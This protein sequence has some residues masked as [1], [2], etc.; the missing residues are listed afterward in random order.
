MLSK[1]Q[2]DVTLDITTN[3]VFAYWADVNQS[4]IKWVNRRYIK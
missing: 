2:G 4:S 3:G 1:T